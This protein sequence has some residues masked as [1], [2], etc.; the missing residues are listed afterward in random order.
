MLFNAI[1]MQADRKQRITG[2]RGVIGATKPERTIMCERNTCDG[3]Y[4]QSKYTDSKP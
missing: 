2:S 1:L 3:D 4:M